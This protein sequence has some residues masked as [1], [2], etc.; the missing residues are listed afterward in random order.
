[1]ALVAL[2]VLAACTPKP[3]PHGTPTAGPSLHPPS[4]APSSPDAKAE[5]Q[6]AVA[7]YMNLLSAYT[8]AS[9]SGTTA[10]T[11]LA[12]YATGSALQLLS[13]GLADNK[14]KGLHSQGT[15]G[16]DPPKVTEIAPANGP[17]MVTV[18]GCV[19]DTHWQLYNSNGQRVD[20]G[21]SGSRPTS[22]QIDKNG[23][24]WKVSS[25]AIQ[26]VG[27]CTG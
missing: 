22:A 19:D 3:A 7:A 6:A 4:P 25:L 27:T 5:V 8:A 13:S 14:A 24:V 15:P 23:G 9:N 1:V 11:E 20:N 10:T 18:A 26:G 16:I 12:K 2:L 21:P 17:T